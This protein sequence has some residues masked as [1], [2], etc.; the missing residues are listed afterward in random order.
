MI[1]QK[2]LKFV[3]VTLLSQSFYNDSVRFFVT[4]WF[5]FL[6]LLCPRTL[7]Q[8]YWNLLGIPVGIPSLGIFSPRDRTWV[9]C[10]VGRFC[11]YHLSHKGSSLKIVTF[12]ILKVLFFSPSFN[13]LLNYCS[14]LRTNILDFCFVSGF[15]LFGSTCLCYVSLISFYISFWAI[16]LS[17]KT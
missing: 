1:I 5:S 15:C 14:V 17:Q 4:P 8:E 16:P 7:R 6:R 2:L 11:I 9:F 3:S 10:L 12:L 13:Y